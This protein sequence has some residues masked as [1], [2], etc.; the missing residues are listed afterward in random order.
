MNKILNVFIAKCQAAGR[1]GEGN[2]IFNAKLILSM[3]ILLNVITVF[4]FIIGRE[5]FQQL[6][7]FDKS[8]KM[9]YCVGGIIFIFFLLSLLYPRKKILSVQLTE[10]QIK[11]LFRTFIV[12]MI[13]TV[14]VFA[15]VIYSSK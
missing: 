7:P 8:E 11:Y 2:C 15:I 1:Y 10:N 13:L 5:Q 6:L 12:Y 14:A 9:L 3:L 4:I